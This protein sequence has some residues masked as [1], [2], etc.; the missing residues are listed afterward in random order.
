MHVDRDG[1]DA[2]EVDVEVHETKPPGPDL[3]YSI[4]ET[5]PWYLCILLGFQVL[6][7]VLRQTRETCT[8]QGT[9]VQS[10]HVAYDKWGLISPHTPSILFS[11]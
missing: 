8:L 5:P 1:T 4:E 11:L 3:L 6:I 2:T 10:V 7:Q 9:M